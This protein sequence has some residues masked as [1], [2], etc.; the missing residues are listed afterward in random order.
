LT[1]I[2]NHVKFYLE[3]AG[4]SCNAHNTQKIMD[5]F[6]PHFN[7]LDSCAEPGSIEPGSSVVDEQPIYDESQITNPDEIS[8]GDLIREHNRHYERV[9]EVWREPYEEKEGSQPQ[10]A[11]LPLSSGLENEWLNRKFLSDRAV[12]AYDHSK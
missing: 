11:T 8:S 12:V 10:I 1:K 6:D 7:F 3:V 9:F 2:N 5:L 4:F